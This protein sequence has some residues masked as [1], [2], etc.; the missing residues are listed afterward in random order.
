MEG[1]PHDPVWLM[2][3]SSMLERVLS[4]VI[5]VEMWESFYSTL[6]IG[7]SRLSKVTELLNLS[8]RRSSSQCCRKKKNHCLSHCEGIKL[9]D[10]A[11][12]LA[13]IVSNDEEGRVNKRRLVS[14]YSPMGRKMFISKVLMSSVQILINMLFVNVND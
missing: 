7:T 3:T 4:I 8:A 1:L 11:D 10:L 13:K 9:L 14:K 2:N 6:V 5:I 12:A